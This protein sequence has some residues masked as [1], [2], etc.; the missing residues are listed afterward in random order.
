MKTKGFLGMALALAL[1]LSSVMVVSAS[2]AEVAD[3]S[4]GYL[5]GQQKNSERHA[6]YEQAATLSNDA[7]C[8]AFFEANG[9]GGG[10]HSDARHLDADAL[11]AAGIIDQATADSIHQY[12]AD[13]H[14][15]ISGRYGSM[16]DMT[17]TERH[18]YYAG[19]DRSRGDSV[20][21]LLAA[22]IITQEQAEAINA[23]LAE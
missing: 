9:I 15:Q 11:V 23:Y 3:G 16:G 2:A 7:A 20:D 10:M 13:K 12:A 6:Q 21:A 18:A 19:F 4:Y 17:P 22:G 8:K 1:A 14:A 5:A